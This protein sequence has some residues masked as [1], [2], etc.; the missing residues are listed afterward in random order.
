VKVIEQA[1]GGVM[2]LEP[3]VFG[4]DRG[5]FCESFNAARFA[6]LGLPTQFLQSNLSRSQRGVLRGLHYQ[7]PNPQG[8]LVQVVEGEVLDVAVDLRRGSASFGQSYAARLSADNRRLMYIPEGYAHGFAVL[9]EQA[10]F[11]Y[12]CTALYDRACD[13]ALRWNDPALAI[14]W[15]LDAPLLSPKDAAA[16]LLADLGADALPTLASE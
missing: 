9:S 1:L 15:L 7:W 10:S 4:D 5:W 2:L 6:E 12:Q 3:Q 16:P 13:R 11:A 8:K 14:D